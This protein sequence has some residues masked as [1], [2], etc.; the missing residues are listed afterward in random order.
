MT[1]REKE[2]VALFA[3]D[4]A[5]CARVRQADDDNVAAAELG[6][7]LKSCSEC[8]RLFTPAHP[9]SRF[10]GPQCL[11]ARERRRYRERVGAPR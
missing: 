11:A 8:G 1:P 6:L 10:C 9:A 3:A 7:R 4:R 2:L 5:Y